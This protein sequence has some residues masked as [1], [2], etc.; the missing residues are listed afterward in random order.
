MNKLEIYEHATSLYSVEGP[1]GGGDPSFSFSLLFVSESFFRREEGGRRGGK[2][3]LTKR[4]DGGVR[5]EVSQGGNSPQQD[6]FSLFFS[7]S[8]LFSRIKPT[9]MK[10][11]RRVEGGRE[12]K[13]GAFFVGQGGNAL[14]EEGER[15]ERAV[16]PPPSSSAFLTPRINYYSRQAVEGGERKH[17][18]SSWLT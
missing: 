18:A 14:W 9:G 8:F 4:A 16:S 5:R 15:G 1:D 2:K 12:K 11:G 17:C 13:K 7:I 6:P 10:K 3:G